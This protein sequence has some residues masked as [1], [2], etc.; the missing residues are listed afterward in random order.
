MIPLTF[1]DIQILIGAVVF[2]M[3][4]LCILLG[5][6]VLISRG[7]TKEIKRLASHSARLGQKGMAEEVASLVTSASQLV[8]SLNQLVRTAS[9]AGIF[10]ISLGMGMIAASYWIVMQIQWPA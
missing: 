7:Y 4:D 9:G 5:A 3:G 6:F 2:L 10:L 1:T 8:D